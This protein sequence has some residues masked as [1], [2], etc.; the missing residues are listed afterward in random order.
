MA[1]N[2]SRNGRRNAIGCGTSWG[3][4]TVFDAATRTTKSGRAIT[5][6]GST[7]MRVDV[8]T[9]IY[10]IDWTFTGTLPGTSG[11]DNEA[12]LHVQWA[13]GSTVSSKVARNGAPSIFA[14]DHDGIW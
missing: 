9:V 13:P 12:D 3:S 14:Y 7:N 1:S 11:G 4:L 5:S 10:S 2:E 6:F 8:G